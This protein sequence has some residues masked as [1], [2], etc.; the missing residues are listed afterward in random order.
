MLSWPQFKHHTYQKPTHMDN[1][2]SGCSRFLKHI[3]ITFDLNVIWRSLILKPFCEKSAKCFSYRHDREKRGH[4]LM[5]CLP[6]FNINCGLVGLCH[7]PTPS[8]LRGTPTSGCHV[9]CQE[10][11]QWLTICT[12]TSLVLTILD[13]RDI[14]LSFFDIWQ[15]SV[16]LKQT[17]HFYSVCHFIR[18]T[19]FHCTQTSCLSRTLCSHPHCSTSLQKTFCN[20]IV[21]SSCFRNK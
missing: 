8:P 1:N 7:S 6:H 5:S 16:C 11:C 3:N 19:C 20:W 2:L 18:H 12:F 21:N 14:F 15:L 13:A 4:F 10:V 9:F 17:N